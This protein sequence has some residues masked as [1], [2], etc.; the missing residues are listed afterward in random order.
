MTRGFTVVLPP[1]VSLRL[2]E[3]Q[4]QEIFPGFL[5]RQKHPFFRRQDPLQCETEVVF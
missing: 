1:E 4:A 3:R 5:T 2:Q